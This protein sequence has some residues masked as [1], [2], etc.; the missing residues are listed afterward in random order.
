[1]PGGLPRPIDVKDHACVACSIDK[2]AGVSLFVQRAR[3]QIGEKERA[4]GFC[5]LPGQ[6]RKKARER[7]AGGQSLAV[8]QGHEGLRKRQEL[9]IELL[10]R[11]FAADG[12]AEEHGEKIDD[13]VVP[14]T[15]AS[16]AHEAQLM[17][18]RTPCLRR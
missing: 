6:A 15:T 18:E 5:G 12:V 3:E 9:L 14:E 17:A 16:Q 13:F 7:R 1:L 8:E 11:A 10:Q 2:L 4:Q